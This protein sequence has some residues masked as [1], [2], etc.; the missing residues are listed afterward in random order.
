MNISLNTRICVRTYPGPDVEDNQ[1]S[2]Y[3][4]IAYNITINMELLNASVLPV[5]VCFLFFPSERNTSGHQTNL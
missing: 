4:Y 1:C 2:I 5:L 3:L